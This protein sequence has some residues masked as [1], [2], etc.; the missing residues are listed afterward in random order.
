[1]A[2]DYHALGLARNDAIT[3][4]A[5]YLPPNHRVDIPAVVQE[6]Y[7]KEITFPELYQGTMADY[8]LSKFNGCLY[9][10]EKEDVFWHWNG[11]RWDT[12]L[13]SELVKP[14]I[15]NILR[16]QPGVYDKAVGLDLS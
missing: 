7:T 9:K 8:V 11:Q 13:H 3:L 4:I 12:S 1:M 2:H 16:T 10:I 6:T 5:A 15:L 14:M